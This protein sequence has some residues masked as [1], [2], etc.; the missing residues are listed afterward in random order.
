M[1]SMGEVRVRATEKMCALR[2]APS[3][4]LSPE[5]GERRMKER[6]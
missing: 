4:V 2:N 3:P 5:A 1:R 6:D